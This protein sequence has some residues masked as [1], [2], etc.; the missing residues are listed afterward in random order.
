MTPTMP[1][2]GGRGMRSRPRRQAG[3]LFFNG[4]AMNGK[5]AICPASWWLVVLVFLAAVSPCWAA[6]P[7]EGS[8]ALPEPLP[9]EVAVQWALIHN[10]ELAVIREQH[11][12]AAAGVV[13][14]QTYPFNPFW[15]GKVLPNFGPE[16]AGITNS[17]SN[18]HK[19]LLE[20]EVRRQG[21]YR[22][23]GSAA[24]LSRTDW[25][26]AFQELGVA[27]RVMRAF[28]ATL[29]RQEKLRLV[30]QTVRLNDDVAKQVAK[31]V[32]QAQLRPGDLILARTE[33]DDTRS[34]LGTSRTAVVVARN[35]LRRLLGAVPGMPPVEGKLERP[36]ILEDCSE[37][38]QNALERRA[39][40]QARLAAVSEAEARLRLAQ[41]DRFGNP[42]VGPTYAYDDSRVNY[43]GVQITVPLPVLN[44]R[45]GEIMQREAERARAYQDL[46][47]TEIQIRQEV[48]AALD[49]L[50]EAQTWAEGYRMQ[51]IPNLKR[52]LEEMDRLFTQN[53]PGTDVLRVIDIRRKLLK[54]QEG[55]LDALSELNQARADLVG[56]VGDLP[57]IV[58]PPERI[59]APKLGAPP[60]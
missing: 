46:Q 26:I 51:T 23:E 13:I 27:V 59:P 52:A 57:M 50:K 48:E 40:R 19:L 24:A 5:T 42:V 31:L 9:L 36:V 58:D 44:K 60:P 3:F 39:D 6:P 20:L 7:L 28:D 55:Y 22:R 29:Y 49:R 37:L 35:E 25:E 38:I 43:V 17:V 2:I 32:E 16:S 56:A 47:Q 54:A 41:A 1:E 15:E 10:P 34:Q 14:A 18:E 12:I 53:Q 45:Q 30:E 33:V 11:G 21:R 4:Q 8:E